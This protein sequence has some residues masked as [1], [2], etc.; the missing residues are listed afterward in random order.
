MN[1][2]DKMVRIKQNN[3]IVESCTLS[4]GV[5]TCVIEVENT[6]NEI[7]TYT[8]TIERLKN[9]NNYLA[10]LKLISPEIGFEDF[11]R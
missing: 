1:W 5:N 6:F 10:S 9:T 11:D 8:Y 4:V 3:E 7:N 2:Q